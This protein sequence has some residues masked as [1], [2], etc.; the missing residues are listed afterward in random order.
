MSKLLSILL[1]TALLG[2]YSG[3][4]CSSSLDLYGAFFKAGHPIKGETIDEAAT[5]ADQIA[6]LNRSVELI[7][8][9][10][11]VRFEIAGHTDQYECSGQECRYLAQRRALLLY[12]FLLAAGVDPLCVIAL[13]EYGS[14][15]PIAGKR[16]ENS[17]N[18]RAELNVDIEP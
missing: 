10:P 18:Q 3:A 13:T 8:R 5:G 17:L 15:R 9:H 4:A 6:N 11:D 16:E 14:T 1:S 12:M 7:K 2:G